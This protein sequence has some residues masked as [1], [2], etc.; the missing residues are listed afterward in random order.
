MIRVVKDLS[1]EQ[2]AVV[3]SILG[4]HVLDEESI[5]VRAMPPVPDWLQRAWRGAHERGI[6]S[7]TPDDIQAEID[8]YR[9][10]K[11]QSVAPEDRR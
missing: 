9:R 8:E 6:D 5:S 3:E 11:R 7:L 4:R 2:R 1:P 10:E